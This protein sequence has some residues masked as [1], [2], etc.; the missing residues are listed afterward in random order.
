MTG[1]DE[2]TFTVTLVVSV[3]WA[4]VHQQFSAR[5]ETHCALCALDVFFR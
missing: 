5:P 1:K 3:G 2:I 4:R